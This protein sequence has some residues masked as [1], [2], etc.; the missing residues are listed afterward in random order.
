MPKSGINPRIYPANC[1]FQSFNLSI[2][3]M[4]TYNDNHPDHEA[5]KMARQKVK[6]LK[7]FYTH[8]IVYVLVNAFVLFGKFSNLDAH[9]NFWRFDNFSLLFYWGI[10]LVAHAFS[11]FVPHFFFGSDW[12]QRKVKAYMDRE[13]KDKWE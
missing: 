13:K 5:Y 2:I 7:G 6:K 1:V 9:E 8:L 10:G 4:E 3:K 12:E 11:T